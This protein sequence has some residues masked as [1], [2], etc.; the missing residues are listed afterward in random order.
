MVTIKASLQKVHSVGVS[1]HKRD[2][3]IRKQ[4]WIDQHHQ[5]VASMGLIDVDG[6][7]FEVVPSSGQAL[8][9]ASNTL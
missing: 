9:I 6:L 2:Q 8:K 4:R 1:L 7:S 3:P 5:I